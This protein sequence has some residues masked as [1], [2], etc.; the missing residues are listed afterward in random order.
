[1][2]LRP[3][4]VSG[5]KVFLG[6]GAWR[7]LDVVRSIHPRQKD[8]LLVVFVSMWTACD[9]DVAGNGAS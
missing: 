7:R 2:M 3:L 1:M 5:L 8:V 6:H 9:D 4:A